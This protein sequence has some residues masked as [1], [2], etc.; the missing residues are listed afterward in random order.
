[1]NEIIRDNTIV[2]QNKDLHEADIDDEKVM[3]NIDKGKYYGLNSVGTRIWEIVSE[4]KTI[5]EIVEIL[6][7]EY[8]V[9][10]EECRQAV[11]KFISRLQDEGMILVRNIDL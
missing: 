3:M 11:I 2:L 1:M 9:S 5:D 6:L 8:E 10:L 4:P 7:S